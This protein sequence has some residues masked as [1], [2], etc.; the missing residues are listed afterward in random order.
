MTGKKTTNSLLKPISI[1]KVELANRW[2]DSVDSVKKP[3]IVLDLL[4]KQFPN[5]DIE[6]VLIKAVAVNSLYGTNVL[7]IYNAAKHIVTELADP[8]TDY[9]DDEFISRLAT[10]TVMQKGEYK[11]LHLISFASKYA[12]FYINS[13]KFPMYD[14][15]ARMMIKTHIAENDLIRN[16]KNPYL[17]FKENFFILK[18]ELKYKVSTRALDHYLWFAGQLQTWQKDHE[19]Q[20]NVGLRNLLNSK[21][22]SFEKLW[23]GGSS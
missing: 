13:E 7:A 22:Q 23:L 8:N 21:K 15:Y 3:D 2:F 1:D 9:D 17:A 16:A 11:E 10:I 14:N 18:E 12:H 19:S 6:S 5:N 4:A 20:M